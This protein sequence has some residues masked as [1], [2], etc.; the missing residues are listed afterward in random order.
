MG[1]DAGAA[2]PGR[3]GLP[4]GGPDAAVEGGTAQA[5]DAEAVRQEDYEK[6]ARHLTAALPDARRGDAV[7]APLI[8]CRLALAHRGAG[9]EDDARAC[10]QEAQERL[11][12]SGNVSILTGAEVYYTL[13]LL[14]EDEN[15]LVLARALVEERARQIRNDSYREHFL[16]RTW[17]N[18]AILAE[19][20]EA[21]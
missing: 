13:C 6:A 15:L 7:E 1:E 21:P 14:L 10:A 3:S 20:T 17:P 8:L 9:R 19:G 11:D 16:T 12:A 4:A 2:L 18:A 5:T